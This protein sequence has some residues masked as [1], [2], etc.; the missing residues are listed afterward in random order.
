MIQTIDRYKGSLLGL[1]VGDCVGVALEFKQPGTFQPV[2]DML[3]GGP[4]RLEKGEYTDDTAMALC[5][6]D[7]LLACS[8]FDAHDQMKRYV[9]WYREG[10][11][12]ATGWCF[13]I[14]NTTADALKLFEE[15]G[16]PFCGSTDEWSA[17]NGSIMRLCPI[18]LFY[19]EDLEAGLEMAGE[20]SRTTH[21]ERRA[22]DACRYMS[23]LIMGALHGVTKEE[24][25][26]PL[27]CPVPNAW[28]K[29]PL[30]DELT[31][32]AKG[33]FKHKQPPEIKGTGYVV[34]SLEAAL[35]AFY[36]GKSFEE[37]LLLAVNLG[38]DA[39][40]TGA[41]YGQIAGAYYGVN[42][43]PEKWLSAVKYG[44]EIGDL[45]KQLYKKKSQ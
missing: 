2:T 15:T 25:L 33:S 3:G 23:G 24:L 13:D 4:F 19:V 22:V 10:Y 16:K 45:A 44:D 21:G 34:D 1:A 11:R 42:A 32:V 31:E 40:T 41:V 36:H 18:S 30:H 7:S 35:W 20:S 14:G 28:E 37:G 29:K 9:R 26:Q 39:D 5:L 12:S 43:I 6:A 38:N 17:G 27:Y 8:G